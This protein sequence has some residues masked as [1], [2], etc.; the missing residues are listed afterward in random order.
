MKQK[1]TEL[2][3]EEQQ[4]PLQPCQQEKHHLQ[5]EGSEQRTDSMPVPTEIPHPYG[6]E[7][8]PPN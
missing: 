7:K 8:K 5:S 1:L 4:L 2:E 3:K 6:S